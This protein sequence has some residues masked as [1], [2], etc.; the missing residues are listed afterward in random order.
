MRL[1]NKSTIADVYVYLLGNLKIP[2]GSTVT[3]PSYFTEKQVIE[4]IK[5]FFPTVVL[6]DGYI[7]TED[8]V[9]DAELPGHSGVMSKDTY[10]KDYNNIVD[11]AEHA[12]NATGGNSPLER[13]FSY[14][15]FVNG[16]LVVGTS[17]ANVDITS[18]K[19]TINSV[20]NTG[21]VS[22]GDSINNSSLMA[23]TDNDLTYKGTF[24]NEI[25]Y[26]YTSATV[27]NLYL[28]GLPTTGSG[29]VIISFS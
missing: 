8:D 18:V 24:L 3:V 9:L 1:K 2:P 17:Y 15:D 23:T 28:N 26:V 6:L 5:P 4:A 14:S 27:I 13:S 12:E 19:L 22:V 11:D 29:K 20:F 21:T 7:I 25:D 10:D 16:I